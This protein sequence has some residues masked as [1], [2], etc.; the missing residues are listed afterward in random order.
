MSG[1]KTAVL[2]P[3]L[4]MIGLAA[5]AVAQSAPT[6]RR[7][8]NPHGTLRLAC[9]SCHTAASWRPI[10][11]SP[12]FDHNSQT[13][14]PLLGRHAGVACTLCHVNRVFRNIS[15]ECSSCHADI[16]RRQFG[17]NCQQCHTVKGWRVE[18]RE[19]RE[20]SNR[21]PLI[22]AHSAAA[23]ES[24]HKGA[25]AG[26]FAGLSTQCA[27]CHTADFNKTSNPP[28]LGSPH[29][30]AVRAVPWDGHLVGRE[31]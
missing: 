12:E 29:P 26:V 25:G 13:N 16:H 31:V 1:F 10:R 3:I 17:G 30:A 18:V 4:V 15:R 9:E 22:G 28:H 8:A 5:L 27:A 19:T 7:S 24:C 23:C 6:P 21:F 20:H 2:K 14:W 11:T